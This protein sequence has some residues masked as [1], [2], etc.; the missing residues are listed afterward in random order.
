MA[1]TA[2]SPFRPSGAASAAVET[3]F[4]AAVVVDHVSKA[5]G[6][7]QALSDCSFRARAGEIHAIVGENGSGK[8][9]LAK[10]FSGVIEPD[11]GDVRIFGQWPKSPVEARRLGIATIFQEVLVADD[12]SVLD[13]LYVGSDGF[14]FS[15]QGKAEREQKASDLLR[16]LTLTHIDLDTRVGD[17]TLNL[18]QWIVIGRALLTN[19]KVLILDESS[20]ALD[21]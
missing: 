5:F 19:P 3:G 15:S 21:L 1:A 8:S 4:D 2:T 14:W 18:K 13:N 9:T 16:R 6:E 11:H 17:L 10:T 20:A 12:A 7:T